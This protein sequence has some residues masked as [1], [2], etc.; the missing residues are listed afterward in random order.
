MLELGVIADDLTG[1]M[2]VAS[3]LEREGVRCP[4]V[5][6]VDAL[7]TLDDDTQA[8]VVGRKLL[9]QPPDDARA[10]AKH[11]AEA[12]LAKGTKQIYYKYSA[13]FSSTARGNIGPVA[14]TLMDLTQ[15]DHVFFCPIWKNTTIYQGRL[16]LG[17]IMLHESP[18]RNDP[19]TPM[20]NSNLVEVLQEQS[21]VKVGLLPYQIVVS[22]TDACENYISEQKALG[23]KFFVVDVIHESDLEQLATL[24]RDLPLSTGADLLPVMLARNWQGNTRSQ[25][26]TLLPPAPGYEAV[27]SGSCTG[28]SVRQLAHFE[29]T[30]PVFRI[31]LLEAAQDA[32]MV[33]RIVEWAKDR[34]EKGPVGVGT[35]TDPD[36]VKRAQ[37]KL[38]REGAATLADKLLSS[39]AQHFYQHGVR[40][41]V[42]MGGETSGAVMAALGIERVS[43]ATFDVLNGGYCHRA[44]RDPLSLVLK[45]GGVGEGNFIHTALEQMREA[46]KNQ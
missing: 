14:E 4:L 23:V 15:A 40:K 13:L 9:I 34:L 11:T 17:E 7:N 18:R 31:D 32:N 36:G 43:V 33:D 35:S 41:F 38:G 44:G 39:V 28:K 16:F 29:Q 27:I 1:G 30:H 5:T 8:V 37:A 20:T 42:V 22:G 10:D 24:S 26:K 19:V 12:L 45:A 2:M 6:S 3:L 46:D 25:P 21:Q